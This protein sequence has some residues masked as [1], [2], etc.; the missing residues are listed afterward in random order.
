MQQR[1]GNQ[2]PRPPQNGNGNGRPQGPNKNGQNN[3]SG[4]SPSPRSRI[5]SWAIAAVVVVILGFWAWNAFGRDNNGG[6]TSVDYSILT[7]QVIGADNATHVT[8][9]TGEIDADL[10]SDIYVNGDGALVA[11]GGDGITT[12]NQITAERPPNFDD[13][14]LVQ[15][16]TTNNTAITVEGRQPSGSGFLTILLSFLPFLLFLGLILFMARSMGRGQQNV[17]GFG[18]SKAR[19]HDPERPQVTF[20]DVAG[21]DEAKQELTEVVDFLR[22]PAKYHALGARLPRGVLLVGPPGTGKTLLARAVAGEAGT[23][24]YSVSASEFVEMFV[25][26]GASRVRDLFE[27]AKASA[28]AIIFVDELDAVGRQR[29][30]GLGGSNDEREQTL[31]QMLVEMDGFDTNQ[32]VIVMAAT[33]RPDVLDPALLRPGRFDRQVTI[34]LPDRRGREAIL[35]IHSRGIPL[36]SDI[37]LPSLARGTTGFSG[38]DLANLVNEAALTAA[39]RNRREITPSDFE[40]ALDK[41]LLGTTRNGLMNPKE[42]EVVAYHEAGHAIVAHFTPGSDPLRKV[43]IVPRGRALGVTVQMPDEDRHNY[44]RTYLLGRLAMLLGG[45]A[46]EMVVYD[47]VTTGAESDL[48]EATSLARRMV[49]LWGMSSDVGPIYLGAG[50]EHVF[51]GREITQDKSFSDSTAQRLDT[52]I[53][54]MVETALDRALEV[55]TRFRPQLDLLVAALLEKETIDGTEVTAIFGP[56]TPEDPN[57]GMV[58]RQPQ[59]TADQQSQPGFRVNAD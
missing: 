45:R 53:R 1:D 10:T 31:N 52:A 48:K 13:Q 24:F 37:D 26:V 49:G 11:A 46:A 58:P 21:E 9:G 29:F 39:R 42:R 22:N 36:A 35:N 15:A 28:P 23:P 34:G 6:R 25:G 38:A 27:K 50:E 30:A 5:P 4:D 16:L 57:A 20:A 43:S 47:E 18:R 8:V 3:Q 56:A 44:S 12:T 40:E 14:Q 7:G 51:L 55:N 32:E 2:P 19:Q 41:I 54:D 33:N 59:T 17:F